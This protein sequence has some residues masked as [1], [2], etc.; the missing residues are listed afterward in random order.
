MLTGECYGIRRQVVAAR[1]ELLAAQA[2]EPSTLVLWHVLDIQNNP[3]HRDLLDIAVLFPGGAIASGG[4]LDKPS[5]ASNSAAGCGPARA[6]RRPAATP[7]RG[8]G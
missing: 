6:F 1:K 4:S 7:R 2:E 5:G 3:H 8:E